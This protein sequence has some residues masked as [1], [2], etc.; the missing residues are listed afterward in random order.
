MWDSPMHLLIIVILAAWVA[1][2]LVPARKV[3]HRAGHSGWWSLVLFIPIANLIGLWVFA[4]A[5]WPAL[6]K[7]ASQ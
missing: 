1:A 6:D 5:P 7:A 3:L 4:F 2:I